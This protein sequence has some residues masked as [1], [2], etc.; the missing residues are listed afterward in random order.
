MFIQLSGIFVSVIPAKSTPFLQMTKSKS[1]TLLDT[2]L[3]L[4]R[5]KFGKLGTRLGDI[6]FSLFALVVV[7]ELLTRVFIKLAGFDP[8]RRFDKMLW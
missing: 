1:S 2:D 4:E 7:I 8:L 3:T 6:V 5:K